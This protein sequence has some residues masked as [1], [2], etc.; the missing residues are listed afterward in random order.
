MRVRGMVFGAL[1]T[2][3]AFALNL[4]GCGGDTRPTKP[5]LCYRAN[6]PEQAGLTRE[7]RPEEWIELITGVGAGKTTAYDCTKQTIRWP[8]PP[9]DCPSDEASSE[10]PFVPVVLGEDSV[11]ERRL[12]NGQRLVWI[13]THVRDDGFA[14]GPVALVEP[15]PQGTAVHAI[16]PLRA[17]YER[18]RLVLW[19]IGDGEVL[20]AEGETCTDPQLATTCKRGVQL[21]VRVGDAFRWT[22]LQNGAGCVDTAWIELARTAEVARTDGWIRKLDYVANVQSDPRYVVVTEQV[23]VHD[24]DSR[25]PAGT[26]RL[27][28][29]IDSDRF[30]HVSQGTLTSR[31]PPLWSIAVSDWATMERGL[32]PTVPRDS[33][34]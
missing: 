12:P 16:G 14:L 10:L 26:P 7:L 17:R 8:A 21:L 30:L 33:D 1:A 3:T 6:P 4:A 18:A 34:L 32:E 2:V 23:T 27:V 20:A 5:P 22:P 25:D 24:R 19:S 11:I 31:Q 13:I 29:R 28:R 15:T 9:P